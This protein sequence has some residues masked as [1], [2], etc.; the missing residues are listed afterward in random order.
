MRYSDANELGSP[1]IP[2]LRRQDLKNRQNSIDDLTAEVKGNYY[3]RISQLFEESQH[4]YQEMVST[5]VAKECARAVLPLAAPTRLYMNGTI[6]SWIHY[7]KIRAGVE[8]QMEHREIA[9]AILDIMK[10][11]LPTIYEAAFED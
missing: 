6:R 2:N 8:T 1:R 7:L 9:M 11:E 4:L 5:G 10:E 3:R